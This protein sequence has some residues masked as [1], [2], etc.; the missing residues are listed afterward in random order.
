MT[1]KAFTLSEI[2]IT[3][4]I[5]GVIAAITLPILVKNYQKMV[6]VNSLKDTYTLFNA[7]FKKIIADADCTDL[8]CTGLF[9][10]TIDNNYYNKLDTTMRKTFKIIKSC[11]GTTEC[12]Y[13][14]YGLKGKNTLQP[15]DGMGLGVAGKANYSTIGQYTMVLQNGVNAFIGNRHCTRTEYPNTSKKLEYN[16]ATIIFDTNGKNKPNE[17]G[18]DI[19]LFQ[20]GQ[21][22][23]L[24][25]L[26]GMDYATHVDGSYTNSSNYWKSK[27]SPSYR[28]CSTSASSYGYACS[29]RIIESGWNM[30]Y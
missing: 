22:G 5:I 19:F 12:D 21:D 18:R 7:G 29:A 4:G 24:Y 28:N 6:Y 25:A 8:I 17:Y 13:K 23:T 16:C 11:L 9:T 3:I 27:N 14:T 26:G 1:K 2:L 10:D 15:Y 20:L 30:D